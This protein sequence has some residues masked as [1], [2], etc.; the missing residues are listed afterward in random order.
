MNETQDQDIFDHIHLKLSTI[1]TNCCTP[2]S[3]KV[4]PS[5][6][7]AAPRFENNPKVLRSRSSVGSESGNVT[8]DE[9]RKKNA[10]KNDGAKNATLHRVATVGGT[11]LPK[12]LEGWTEEQQIE[13]IKVIKQ[14]P[15]QVW[16]T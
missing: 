15:V 3:T 4:K 13:L 2:V 10:N 1:F 6:S 5:P 12:P 11:L 7:M 8:F 14:I 9:M 16:A